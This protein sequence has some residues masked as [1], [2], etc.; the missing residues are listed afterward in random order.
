MRASTVVA[1]GRLKTIHPATQHENVNRSVENCCGYV[2]QGICRAASGVL[3]LA[4][5]RKRL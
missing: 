1:T 5:A 3:S 2:T 4:A